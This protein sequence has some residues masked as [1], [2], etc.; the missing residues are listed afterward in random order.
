MG[1]VNFGG[2]STFNESVFFD[3]QNKGKNYQN[4]DYAGQQGIC[5]SY[6]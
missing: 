5:P 2:R 4:I 6:I 3:I 1:I